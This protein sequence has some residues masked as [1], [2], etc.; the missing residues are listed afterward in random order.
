MPDKRKPNPPTVTYAGAY[1]A[2]PSLAPG[3]HRAVPALAARSDLR[4]YAA[5]CSVCCVAYWAQS[6]VHGLGGGQAPA[7]GRNPIGA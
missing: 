6:S 7:L 2:P 3:L 5:A 1:A 4:Q